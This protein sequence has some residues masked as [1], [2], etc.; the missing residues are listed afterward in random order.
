MIEML[1]PASPP[2]E[3]SGLIYGVVVGVVTNNQDPDGL[4]RVKL[5]FPWLS[6]THESHWAR[7]MTPMAG[8]D[9]G[10]YLLPEVEDEVLVMFERGVVEHPFVIGALWNGQD[11]PPA[12]NQDGKNNLRVFKSRSGH[13]VTFDDTAGAEKIVVQDK[14]GQSS[15][16]IAEKSITIE[17]G[18]DLMI[19]AKGNITLET[20]SGDIAIKCQNLAIETQKGYS[21]KG[22]NGT[23]EA[24]NGLALK[25]MAG[26]NLNDGA[27]EVT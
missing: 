8:K 16:V 1:S 5:K 10:L 2:S 27:L 26:I 13:T 15:I 18:Q 9:R 12:Q 24:Q 7:V 21:L 14:S 4:G 3:Q 25:C 11:T 19:Q 17:S 23:V 6:D 20:G 22:P